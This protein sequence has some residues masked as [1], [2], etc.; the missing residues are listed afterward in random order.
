LTEDSIHF[1]ILLLNCII[2]LS[3]VVV[4]E[5]NANYQEIKAQEKSRRKKRGR[6][7]SKGCCTFNGFIIQRPFASHRP[8][9]ENPRRL[10]F[11][12]NVQ[13]L[14]LEQTNS[15]IHFFYET[16]DEME[17]RYRIARKRKKTSGFSRKV[18]PF[19]R[20]KNKIFLSKILFYL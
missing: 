13:T 7:N 19:V 10:E 4:I 17:G 8:K 11:G 9:I 5:T 18:R 20:S 14:L 16:E 15:F 12:P 2:R 1:T 6:K 3:I